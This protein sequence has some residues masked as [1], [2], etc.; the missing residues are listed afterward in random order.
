MTPIVDPQEYYAF[1]FSDLLHLVR[2][3]KKRALLFG[4]LFALV[5][6]ASLGAFPPL[7]K[8][9][10]L[11]KESFDKNKTVSSFIENL[12]PSGMDF[13]KEELQAIT[14]MKSKQI[15]KRVVERL[16]LQV[17]RE[18]GVLSRYQRNWRLY[19]R[20]VPNRFLEDREEAFSFSGVSFLLESKEKYFLQFD[21]LKSF[22]VFNCKGRQVGAGSVGEEVCLGSFRFTLESIPKKFS[23]HKK[24]SIVL[25]PWLDAVRQILKNIS[26][27]ADKNNASF[28]RLTLSHPNRTKEALF[29][30]AASE[31]FLRIC[32]TT[33][34]HGT[35]HDGILLVKR[36]FFRDRLDVNRKEP[37]QTSSPTLPAPTSSLAIEHKKAF[38]RIELKKIFFFVF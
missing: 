13:S 8:A 37:R 35:Q 30:S 20:P 19:F 5:F 7:Y 27:A 31:M 16:G 21:S 34:S 6:L 4:S 10:A 24:Y 15:L 33:S 11:F 22:L 32:R 29:L 18:E 12:L 17:Q 14:L 38:Q 26:L 23:L 1:Y 25:V 9:E 3:S 36:D 28:V 2:S